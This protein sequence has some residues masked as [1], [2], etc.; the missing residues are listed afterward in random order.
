L[1]KKSKLI[2]FTKL[3]GAAWEAEPEKSKGKS[4]VCF[5]EDKMKVF[6]GVVALLLLL[7]FGSAI[8]QQ[9]SQYYDGMNKLG[10]VDFNSSGYGARSRAMG[11]V[12]LAMPNEAYG[13]FENPATMTT[14]N[15]SLMSLEL[16]NFQ[17]KHKG[18]TE[19]RMLT[20]Q[21][22]TFYVG[23]TD[24]K[25]QRTK[26][27]NQAG[28]VA[29]FT[30]AGR[31][32][33]VGGG[34]RSAAD[35]SLEFDIPVNAN[36]PDK[37]EREKDLVGLN[38]AIATKLMENISA[39][40][41]LNLYTRRYE[42]DYIGRQF[43]YADTSSTT[44]D[45]HYHD[46]SNFSGAN[47]DFGL[48]GEL[49]IFTLGAVVRTPYILRQNAFR[50]MGQLDPY[51]A[52]INGYIDRIK[53]KYKIPLSYAFGLAVQ[54]VENITI[55][56]DCDIKPYSKTKKTLD[57]ED[58]DDM[59]YTDKD[60][61]W[62]DL[63]QFRVGAEYVFDA[64]FAKIPVRAGIHNMPN[65]QFVSMTIADSARID[66]SALNYHYT[67]EYSDE[68][69]P[70]II[71]FGSGI[72]FEKIWL[73]VAYEFGSKEYDQAMRIPTETVVDKVKFKYSRLY[74]SVGML[75]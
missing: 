14:V 10:F 52:D 15:K 29:P 56:A 60:A 23:K 71:S 27:V 19:P 70:I 17:D 6:T 3:F 37:Y 63:T 30:Y 65:L 54:P 7:S 73:D 5:W 33:W 66:S 46:K 38:L 48:A 41:N 26:L 16:A 62:N 47:L 49:S 45:Y 31:D 64:G 51:G 8:G 21:A 50:L 67:Y 1:H 28:A 74:L 39:G 58:S 59:D 69:N 75:F 13:S 68:V 24:Y 57:F 53:V 22:N 25:N 36:D 18:L 43:K 32:W 42:E 44:Y 12:Y 55:A 9:Y 35:F 34:Y 2:K 11:G 20:S 40:V 61:Q 4:F 72:K